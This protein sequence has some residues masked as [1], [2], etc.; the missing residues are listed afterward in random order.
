LRPVRI[1]PPREHQ[2]KTEFLLTRMASFWELG[3]RFTA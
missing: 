1:A 3:P 2:S